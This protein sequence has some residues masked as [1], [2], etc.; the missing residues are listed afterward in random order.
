MEPAASAAGF[1]FSGLRI[2]QFRM[3]GRALALQ[4][5]LSR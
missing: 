5:D 2:R 1:A 3:S 4:S